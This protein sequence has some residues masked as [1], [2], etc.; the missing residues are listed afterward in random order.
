MVQPVHP[1]VWGLLGGFS[2]LAVML[3][4]FG[5]LIPAAVCA[6]GA[7]G[8]GIAALV[9]R[10][11]GA[12]VYQFDGR[13]L[14]RGPYTACDAAPDAGFVARLT[15][16]V[17]QLRE[18]AVHDRWAIDWDRFN[19][20]FQIAKTAAQAGRYDEAIRGFCRSISFMMGELKN[21]R[22]RRRSN[23]NSVFE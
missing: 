16:I 11:G 9:Q 19:G 6:V 15:D 2:L 1:V 18:A 17:N 22:S 21:Q 4:L 23:G 14:G 5:L 10:Y 12:P 7:L 3:V 13:P 20:H 8:A